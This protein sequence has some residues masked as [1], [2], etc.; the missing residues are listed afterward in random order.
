[1]GW[2]TVVGTVTCADSPP[3][4]SPSDFSAYG[5][6]VILQI[7]ADVVV[8]QQ[9]LYLYNSTVVVMIGSIH[10]GRYK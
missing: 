8:L 10:V 4:A 7:T 1:M 3:E 2:F 9:Y 5:R 6:L